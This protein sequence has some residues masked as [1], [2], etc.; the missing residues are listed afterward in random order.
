MF[1][2]FQIMIIRYDASR[3]HPSKLRLAAAC[4]MRSCLYSYIAQLQL[5]PDNAGT[6]NSN[7]RCRFQYTEC[8]L[9]LIVFPKAGL[10]QS[11]TRDKPFESNSLSRESLVTILFGGNLWPCDLKFELFFQ[12]F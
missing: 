4:K 11:S 5:E 6:C 12:E 8:V 1:S 7:Y 10:F 2:R 3:L 9:S